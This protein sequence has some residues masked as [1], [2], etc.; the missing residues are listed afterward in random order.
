L[1]KYQLKF[2]KDAIQEWASLD[3][4]IKAELKKALERRLKS[5]IVESARLHGELNGCFKIKSKKSGYRLIYTVVDKQLVVIV[6]A[7]GKRE[8]LAV[9][10]KARLR[11]DK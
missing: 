3:G 8:R 9:Y 2:D 1:D 10:K 4:S 11:N 5:P 6:I 7:I